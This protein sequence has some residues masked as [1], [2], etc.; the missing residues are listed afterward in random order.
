MESADLWAHLLHGCIEDWR[1]GYIDG[2]DLY[3]YGC[4]DGWVHEC[5][6][7]RM[8]TRQQDQEAQEQQ[9]EG[10]PKDYEDKRKEIRMLISYNNISSLDEFTFMMFSV[11]A[12]NYS[13]CSSTSI[14]FRYRLV[15][16]FQFIIDR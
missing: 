6:H 13:L 15:I 2:C 9:W 3:F 5:M 8:H 7:A 16:I 4:E 14:I 12:F 1:L 10:S 11:F